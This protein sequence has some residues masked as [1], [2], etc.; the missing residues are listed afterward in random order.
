MSSWHDLK[1]S[2]DDL[3]KDYEDKYVVSTHGVHYVAFYDWRLH[4]WFGG[5][6]DNLPVRAWRELPEFK[7]GRE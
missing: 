2:P 1:K 7:E 5:G 3:P 6:S 4:R